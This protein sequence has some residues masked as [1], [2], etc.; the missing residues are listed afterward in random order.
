MKRFHQIKDI[1]SYYITRNLFGG[2]SGQLFEHVEL[3]HGDDDHV[4]HDNGDHD[5]LDHGYLNHGDLD[6][7]ESKGRELGKIMP[8]LGQDMYLPLPMSSETI[9]GVFSLHTGVASS[10]ISR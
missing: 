10:Q 4:D 6:H 5:N 9:Q 2:R 1:L 7:G 8:F 3:D